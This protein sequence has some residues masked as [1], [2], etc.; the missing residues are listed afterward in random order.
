[1]QVLIKG[2]NSTGKVVYSWCDAYADETALLLML[3][4]AKAENPS[5]VRVTFDIAL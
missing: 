1:M 5:I 3:K 4:H 2:Y